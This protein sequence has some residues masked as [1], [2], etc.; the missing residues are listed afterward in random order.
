MTVIPRGGPS[1]T[2]PAIDDLGGRLPAAFRIGAAR[3]H[4][5]T[6]LTPPEPMGLLFHRPDG[7]R[8]T[9]LSLHTDVRSTPEGTGD[10]LCVLV[11]QGIGVLGLECLPAGP[12]TTQTLTF[13]RA[14]RV[15][16]QQDAIVL[17]GLPEQSLGAGTL[18]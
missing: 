14:I 17:V 16:R 8:L 18:A 6:G 7:D 1:P 15:R 3:H 2:L 12:P 5:A 13:D 4:S 10:R 11:V 9:P